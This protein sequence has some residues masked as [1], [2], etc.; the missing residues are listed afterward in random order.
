MDRAWATVQDTVIAAPYPSQAG[1]PI[2]LLEGRWAEAR[3]LAEAAVARATI[4]HAQVASAALGVLARWQG[5]PEAAW[6]RVRERHPAGPD[7]APG[8]CHFLPGRAL[9]ALAA[10]LALDAG[11]L[12]TA[13]RWIAAHG[14]WLDWSGTV[15]W[16]AEHALLRARLAAATGDLTTAR[17]QGEAAL[18]RLPG[19]P[20]HAR[21]A[22]PRRWAVRRG[23]DPP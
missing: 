1:L 3:R 9:Q 15:L 14:R 2:A 21:R 19:R 10:E 11:D 16:Q 7:T 17:T 4:G 23:R 8:D 12:A 6:A 18:A 22:E 5:D 13:D 20:A